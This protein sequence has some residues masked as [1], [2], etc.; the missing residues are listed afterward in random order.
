MSEYNVRNFSEAKIEMLVQ[1]GQE[2]K[3]M[4]EYEQAIEVLKK[5]LQYSWVYGRKD[6]EM[7]IYDLLGM[8]YYHQGLLSEGKGSEVLC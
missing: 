8:C 5:A 4:K 7:E 6:E 1:M 2:L 3:M